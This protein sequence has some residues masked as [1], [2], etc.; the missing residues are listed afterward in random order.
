MSMAK[1]YFSH[2]P[3]DAVIYIIIVPTGPDDG[4]WAGIL[5]LIEVFGDLWGI[6]DD[7]HTQTRA[8]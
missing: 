6:Y 1:K 2:V 5:G 3:D 4:G 7:N 8:R